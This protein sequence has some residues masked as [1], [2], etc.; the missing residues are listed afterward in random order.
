MSKKPNRDELAD[1][2]ELEAAYANNTFLEPS[3]WDLK[4]FF[5]QWYSKPGVDWHT[6]VVLPWAQ[7]KL[8]S[9]YLQ[10]NLAVYEAQNGTVH[11]PPST[12]PTAPPPEGSTSEEK[13]I[14]EIVAQMQREFFGSTEQ[15]DN[16]EQK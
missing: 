14:S 12:A 4:I 5:G 15:G 7:V 2:E 9:H 10:V 16:P 6:A 11:I 3:V 13:K 8:L 1:T